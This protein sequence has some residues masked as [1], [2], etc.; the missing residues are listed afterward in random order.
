MNMQLDMGSN[1]KLGRPE[2]LVWKYK[3]YYWE[4]TG[5][6]R[7][8]QQEEW[9][10]DLRTESCDMP[11]LVSYRGEGNPA[12]DRRINSEVRKPKANMMS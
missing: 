11:A 12:R 10:N 7:G 6:E 9:R 4:Y 2:F 1:G 5:V 8:H 3:L